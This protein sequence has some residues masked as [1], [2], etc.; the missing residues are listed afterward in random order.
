VSA[1]SGLPLAL[2]AA[3]ALAIGIGLLTGQPRTVA[4]KRTTGRAD[5]PLLQRLPL[6]P[7]GLIGAA[8][9]GGLG[10]AFMG[11][12]LSMWIGAGAGLAGAVWL[13]RRAAPAD[14]KQRLLL[15]KQFPLVLNFLAL[16]VES[17]APF[18]VAAR[19]VSQVADGPNAERLRSVIARCDV[20]F[21]DSEA[22][23]T[24]IGDPVWGDVARE[25]ARCVD[26]GAAVGDVLRS[27]AVQAAKQHAAEANTRA[28]RVGVSSTLPLVACFLPAFLLVGVVP[29][30]G[31]LIGGYL[32]GW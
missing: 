6:L 30:I 1:H 3:V 4:L 7:A 22:W 24:L 19:A 15:E 8:A 11:A 21:T 28:R 25:L 20:G 27:A 26:S 32:A 9:G 5:N 29:I 12:G 16:V 23:R 17:G 10:W 13:V 31:G 18:R 2:L 14:V